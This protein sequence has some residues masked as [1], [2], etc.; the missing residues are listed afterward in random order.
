[1]PAVRVLLLNEKASAK[2]RIEALKKLKEEFQRLSIL[3]NEMTSHI[4]DRIKELKSD[5]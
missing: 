4:D 2:E 3:F 1:M 5:E